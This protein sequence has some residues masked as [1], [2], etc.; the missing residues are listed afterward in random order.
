MTLM[1][2][3]HAPNV[4]QPTPP[5]SISPLCL[6]NQSVK[7]TRSSCSLSSSPTRTPSQQD[8]NSLSN[9]LPPSVACSSRSASGSAT[10]TRSAPSI[11]K[12]SRSQAMAEVAPSYV[13]NPQDSQVF[14]PGDYLGIFAFMPG[15]TVSFRVSMYA[16]LRQ[17]SGPKIFAFYGQGH[18][19]HI[20]ALSALS[21]FFRREFDA[22]IY[23][24][25]VTS[26]D[27]KNP[28]GIPIVFDPK[29]NLT[30]YCRAL[31]PIAGG[32]H[33]MDVIVIVDSSGKK[34]CFLPVG[35]G[36]YIARPVS[37]EDLDWILGDALRYL[38]YE[39]DHDPPD[40]CEE[41]S[42]DDEN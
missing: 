28:Y 16:L 30:R 2:I 31:H 33:A 29:T 32:R 7:R 39:Q 41:M 10:P 15:S 17:S 1:D 34:R 13:Q 18:D 21:S 8:F 25:S 36:G 38:R 26:P 42:E 11:R 12:R 20:R 24:V 37:L 14:N 22:S 19:H 3:D 6:Q 35:Y 9:L 23:A 5:H 4:P 40:E 27:L